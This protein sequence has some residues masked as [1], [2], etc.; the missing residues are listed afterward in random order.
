[1]IGRLTL[2]PSPWPLD[3]DS[4]LEKFQLEGVIREA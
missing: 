1:M 2:I 3:K 4:S